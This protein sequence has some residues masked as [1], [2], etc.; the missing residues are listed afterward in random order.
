M[1][2]RGNRGDARRDLLA[3][4]VLSHLVLKPGEYSLWNPPGALVVA[5]HFRGVRV[6]HPEVPLDAGHFDLRIRERQSAVGQ[7]QPVDMVA[8]EMREDDDIDGVAVDADRKST[9]LN[10]SHMSI[11][12]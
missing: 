11:S 6:V 1:A 8:M 7:T 2:G 10:S 5:G 9:R 4:L 12:Y 3:R